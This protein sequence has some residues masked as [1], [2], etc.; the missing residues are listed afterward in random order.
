MAG[1]AVRFV[2]IPLEPILHG[3]NHSAPLTMPPPWKG[4]PDDL[5]AANAG[6]VERPQRTFAA[7]P[8]Q[9]DLLE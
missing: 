3:F 7:P 2:G 8:T 9:R 1:E 4:V 5:S 6:G